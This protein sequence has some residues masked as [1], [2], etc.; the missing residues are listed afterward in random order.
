MLK[1]APNTALSSSCAGLFEAVAA[2][3]GICRDGQSYDGQAMAELEAIADEATLRAPGEDR[4]PIA[5]PR[6]PGVGVPYIEPL[7]LWRAL[8]GDLVLKT[9]A[10]VI[11]ARFHNW[12]AE[13]VTTLAVKLARRDGDVP[14]RF[15]NIALSG[16]CFDNRILFEA[17]ALGLEHKG[18]HL[19]THRQIPADDGGLALG[20]AAISAAALIRAK[21]QSQGYASC[22]SEFPAAS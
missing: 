5:I 21:T 6:L 17:V 11:A 22:V 4:Y 2:A 12:L 20:Q 18:F 15:D 9:P 8:L 19:L 14:P 10:P 3:L 13:S 16:A 7:G 1:D